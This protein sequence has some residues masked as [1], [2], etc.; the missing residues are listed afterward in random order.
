MKISV[1]AHPGAKRNVVKKELDILTGED[2]YHVFTS[3]K[4]VDGEANSAI[5][6]LLVDFF[7]IK[8]YQIKLV[9]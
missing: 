6:V 1:I 8:K 9:S 4:A 7:N 5:V 3:S 2:V